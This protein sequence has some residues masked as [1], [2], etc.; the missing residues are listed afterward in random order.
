MRTPRKHVAEDGSV[1]WKVRFRKGISPKTGKPMQSSETFDSYADA[2]EFCELLENMDTP[3]DALDY[4]DRRAQAEAAAS[5]TLDELAEHFCG[6]KDSDAESDR[7]AADYRR[8]Y[9]NWIEPYFKGNRPA[10]SL[11]ERDVQSWVD[12]MRA[13]TKERTDK[14]TG[15]KIEKPALQPKSILDKHALLH[16]MYKFGSKPSRKLVQHNPVVGTDLPKRRK[17]TAKGFRPAEWV[18]FYRAFEQLSRDAADLVLFMVST[19]WRWSEATKLR[20]Y[21]VEDDGTN[22]WVTMGGVIR[23]NAAGTF[24]EVE[25]SGKSDASLGRRIKL[26]RQ[27]SA[28]VR[29]RLDEKVT[30]DGYVFTNENGN[31]WH[32]SNFYNRYWYK[33][34]EVANLSRR[35]TPHWLR[36][37]HAGWLLMGDGA[38][39]AEVQKRIGHEEISTTVDVYGS[40]VSDVKDDALEQFAAMRDGLL[41]AGP[42][43]PAIDS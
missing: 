24:V 39:L 16:G 2:Y 23:R 5:L 10:N 43:T 1:S 41:T 42:E 14:V 12:W 38:N 37:T 30:G 25:D 36:H 29:R 15:E 40:L 33:A 32:Q 13:Q 4:I 11:T 27:A 35:P 8:D 28:M 22:V 21:H 34:V 26:D 31:R 18:A 20:A 3:Q 6:W 17:R 7:T 9:R 19:G